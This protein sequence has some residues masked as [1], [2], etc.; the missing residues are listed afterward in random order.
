[1]LC[2]PPA[3]ILSQDHTL[4]IMVSSLPAMGDKINSE[5][6]LLFLLFLELYSLSEFTRCSSHILHTFVCP[7]LHTYLL[8]FNFQ[9][10]FSCPRFYGSLHII[11]QLYP[12]C[13]AFLTSFFA[14]LSD[15]FKF[16]HFRCKST[17]QNIK[18]VH[19]AQRGCLAISQNNLLIHFNNKAL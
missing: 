7:L 15:I 12:C 8:L 6:D 4:E 14:F 11:S 13:Q 5:L 19:F 9:G 16:R 18:F 10:P 3:L 17:K 2:T 1:M